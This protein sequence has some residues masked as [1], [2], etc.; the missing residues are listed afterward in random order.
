MKRLL[1]VVLMV[2]CSVSWA[3]WELV[4]K[5]ADNSL[6]VDTST[7]RK[8]GNFVKMWSM[9]NYTLVQTTGKWKWRSMML[10]DVY[11]CKE[12]VMA[13]VQVNAFEGEMASGQSLATETYQ[14][15]EWNWRHV[16]PGSTGKI[17]WEIACADK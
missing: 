10:L 2:T 6:F 9:R 14:Q 3:E 1:F 12:E 13:V 17:Q 8:S 11:N 16:L 4:G 5:S 7:I 15:S